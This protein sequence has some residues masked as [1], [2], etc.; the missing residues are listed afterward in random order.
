MDGTQTEAGMRFN[1]GSCIEEEEEE[2]EENKDEDR[3]GDEDGSSPS[4]CDRVRTVSAGSRD[5][6]TVDYHRSSPSGVLALAWLPGC[7][8]RWI[9]R[10][11]ASFA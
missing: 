3:D 8:S 10:F 4:A 2:E 11:C 7:L 6:T 5:G 1:H 9:G